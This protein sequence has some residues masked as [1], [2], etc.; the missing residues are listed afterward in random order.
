LNGQLRIEPAEIVDVARHDDGSLTP[1]GKDHRS[2]DHVRGSRPAAKNACGFCEDL[3][4]GGDLRD[5]SG[6]ESAQC[7][8]PRAVTPDLADDTCWNYQAPACSQRLPAE[9]SHAG[10]PSLERDER[11]RV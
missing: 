8:L 6:E 2:I 1:G 7:D 3:V 11:A 5:R 4:E 10:V 9:R